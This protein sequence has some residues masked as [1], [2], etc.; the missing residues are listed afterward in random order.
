MRSRSELDEPRETVKYGLP[1]NIACPM[2][3]QAVLGS[4]KMVLETGKHPEQLKDEV[5]SPGGTTIQ[6]VSAL[7][8]MGFRSALIKACDACYEKSTQIK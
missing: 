6:G 5:C 3:A 2:A 8:E 7:E 1:R 4:A